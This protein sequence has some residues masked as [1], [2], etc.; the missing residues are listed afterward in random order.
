MIE[1]TI[2]TIVFNFMEIIII[3]RN[4]IYICFDYHL[5]LGLRFIFV[6]ISPITFLMLALFF[7]LN[8]INLNYCDLL[9]H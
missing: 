9:T 1:A 4:K 7:L 2:T 3:F 5:F 6:D 8:N